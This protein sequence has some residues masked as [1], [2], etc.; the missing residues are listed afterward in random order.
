MNK[1]LVILILVLPAFSLMLKNGIY[2][3]HDFHLFRQFE[4]NKCVQ[5]KVFPCRWAPDA[6]MG[7]GEPLFNFYGQFPY[8]VGQI[9]HT[10]GFSII[11]SIKLL[12]ILSLL[13]SAISMYVLA[14]VYWGKLGGILSAIFYV[15]A[16]YRAVDIW[17][18]G[19]LNEAISFVYFPFIFYT[20][21]QYLLY[22]K[23]NHLLWFIISLSAL[24]ITHNLSF[25]MFIPFLGLFT[26]YRLYQKRSIASLAGLLIAGLTT[27]FLSSFYLLPVLLENKLTILTQITQ[28]YYFYQLHWATL[29]QLF[30][31]N[32]WGYGGSVWGPNDTLSFSVGYFHWILPIIIILLAL[33]K[34]RLNVYLLLFVIFGFFAAFLTHGKSELI[35]KI[36]SPMS[37]IQFP[38]RF[39]TLS[40]FFLS[41]ASGAI[42]T[43]FTSRLL[44]SISLV[45]LLLLNFSYFKP[46]IWRPISDQE[47]FSGKLWDEQRASALQD[48]W[49][50]SAPRLPDSFAPD[51]PEFI[52]GQGE[53]LS[54]LKLSHSARYSFFIDSDYAKITFPIVNFPGWIGY[55]ND[56]KLSIFTSGQ[57]GLITTSLPR[58]QHHITL[59]FTDTLPRAAG[60]LISLV[61]FIYI[62]RK[63][64]LS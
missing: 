31:S 51:S 8:W 30:I 24:L 15:Y 41:L 11:D 4:F 46:D 64:A 62:C 45:L 49:P 54:A 36:F 12:F 17:V 13:L 60:N 53:T 52:I 39:L 1:L 50:K 34:R 59:K 55:V 10:L 25:L 18:R 44:L 37:F 6:G 32:F 63:L 56:Q 27:V 58:G 29:R 33:L 23:K 22:H 61:T 2:T 20:L 26:L 16:P 35:W 5:E 19:A 42:S 38:W 43:I 48:F 7:Y 21:D 28:D 57:L 3:M 14:K 47:Q 9:F 40:T